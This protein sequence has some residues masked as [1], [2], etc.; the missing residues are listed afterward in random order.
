MKERTDPTQ[1]GSNVSRGLHGVREAARRDKG[2]K[3]TA[4]LH[5]VTR[6]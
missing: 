6:G 4:L 1:G 5:H 3:F 2:Q